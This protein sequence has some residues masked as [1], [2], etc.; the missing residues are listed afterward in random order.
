MVLGLGLNSAIN[1]RIPMYLAKDDEE[2]IRKV[3]STALFFF[4]IMALVLVRPDHRPVREDRRLV[5]DR[6]GAR[7]GGERA[8]LGRRSG[9][10]RLDPAATDDRG[11][12]RHAA[13]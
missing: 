2:G 4:S 1:R 12:Q 11:A 5:H 9:L 3:V 8:D 7:P 10:R 13:V 6:A